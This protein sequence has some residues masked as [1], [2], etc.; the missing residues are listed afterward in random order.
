MKRHFFAPALLLLFP[1][2]LAGC[3]K[4][5]IVG[6]WQGKVPGAGLTLAYEFTEDG[7]ERTVLRVSGTPLPAAT[8]A[9]GT[10]DT[11][12]SSGTYTVDGATLTQNLTESHVGGIPSDMSSAQVG[13]WALDGDHLT[14][15]DSKVKKPFELTRVKD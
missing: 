13:T 4:D 6:K 11:M 2:L 14:L 15:T 10:A 1:P 7:H 3:H 12:G 8:D 9:K 5:T